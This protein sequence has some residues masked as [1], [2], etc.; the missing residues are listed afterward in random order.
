VKQATAE[1]L[2]NS[3]I[4]DKVT[5]FQIVPKDSPKRP[6]APIVSSLI[7]KSYS[8]IY[9][10]WKIFGFAS[11]KEYNLSRAERISH[12]V[13]QSYKN[14]ISAR[15][16]M[17]TIKFQIL[18]FVR[19][20]W[21]L[22]Y[23]HDLSFSRLESP[24]A[25]LPGRGERFVKSMKK[26]YPE[27]FRCFLNTMLIS[28]KG[29]LPRPGME[30]REEQMDDWYNDLFNCVKQTPDPQIEQKIRYYV[31]QVIGS[32]KCTNDDI[33]REP[34]LPSTSANYILGRNDAGGLGVYLFR[35]FE[36]TSK[37]EENYLD[38]PETFPT[39][40]HMHIRGEY[41]PRIVDALV[42]GKRVKSVRP[43][44]AFVTRTVRD[45]YEMMFRKE[46]RAAIKEKPLVAP[47]GLSEALK[48]RMIT[49]C[50]PHLMFV[51]NGFINPLRAYLRGIPTF[52]LT[53]TPQEELIMDRMFP[54]PSRVFNSGDY[55]SSTDRLH[56]W[57]SEVIVEELMNTFYSDVEDLEVW[58]DLFRRSLT[59]FK[60]EGP[61][62]IIRDQCRGQLM[63]SVSSFPVLC[64]ANYA[65]CK[66]AMEENPRDWNGLLINGD[67]CVFE[68][69]PTCQEEWKRV[70]KIMGLEPSPGKVWWERN[71]IQMNSRSF[72][73]LKNAQAHNQ[74][75]AWCLN[76]FEEHDPDEE[77]RR[78]FVAI[79][80]PRV[81][82][83]VPIVLCGAARALNR[84]SS[85][86]GE[87]V[88]LSK[89]D[90][91]GSLKAF[92][93]ELENAPLDVVEKALEHF[94]FYYKQ[95]VF[96]ALDEQ[97][98]DIRNMIPYNLPKRFG[99][100]GL[101]GEPSWKDLRQ[102][103]SLVNSGS[104][105]SSLDEKY[106]FFRNLV[107]DYLK[108]KIQPTFEPCEENWGPIYWYILNRRPDPTKGERAHAGVYTPNP[109]M[110]HQMKLR[111]RLRELS[112][113]RSVG[114][115]HSKKDLCSMPRQYYSV[116]YL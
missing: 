13:L 41:T 92:K 106:F 76:S 72:I 55:V 9:S 42:E 6:S 3:P 23:E 74:R 115:V 18:S 57:V 105:L 95:G 14:P 90:Y 97:P 27:K 46:F 75:W 73:P 54:D 103:S 38:E 111:R 49:K 29:A 77:I 60:C 83:K 94:K 91:E 28:V 79:E 109:K 65:L 32:K 80:H 36:A 62:G 37:R 87:G 35:Y 21:D 99:G 48:V 12:K 52:E 39:V 116:Y 71:Y 93:F 24:G 30:A 81:W 66:I 113:I 108:D 70:G 104:C 100:L 8:R 40:D 114:P 64:L 84:S 45:H 47:V 56:S 98:D 82:K 59:G 43:E 85:G 51:M 102:A 10:V 50:P 88:D 112:R 20:W 17:K 78:N 33:Y 53:G 31:R 1:R 11:E 4:G 19:Y 26:R 107:V 44:L 86:D 58:S 34:H 61:D 25:L 69:S 7:A 96:R 89:I 22:P 15:A 101:D 67:D 110:T 5:G 68:S 63:G 2:S 16:W